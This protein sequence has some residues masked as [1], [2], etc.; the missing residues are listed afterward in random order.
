MFCD[1]HLLDYVVKCFLLALSGLYDVQICKKGKI[2]NVMVTQRKDFKVGVC[3]IG[4][5]RE[6]LLTDHCR[7]IIGNW[8]CLGIFG[9][10]SNV[11]FPAESVYSL[12]LVVLFVSVKF[13]PDY[14]HIYFGGVWFF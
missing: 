1:W 7:L 5:N 8:K 9:K 4:Y 3:S 2:N 14:I 13:G 11:L 12:S 10:S 6:K